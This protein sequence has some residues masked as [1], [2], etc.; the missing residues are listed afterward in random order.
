MSKKSQ[1]LSLSSV[2][3]YATV[4]MAGTMGSTSSSPSDFR[5]VVALLGGYANINASRSQ[6]FVGTD[7]ELFIYRPANNGQ[8]SGFFG[9]FAGVEHRLPWANLSLQGGVEYDYYWPAHVNGTNTVGIQPSTS[10]LYN[11]QYS[12]DTQQLL[13]AFKLFGTVR[14][15]FHPYFSFGLGMAFNNASQFTTFTSQSGS[16]NLTPSFIDQD[17]T[18]FSYNLGVGVDVNMNENVRLGLGYRYS[19][20]GNISFTNGQ[21]VLNSYQFPLPFNLGAANADAHELLAQLTYVF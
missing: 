16:L 9:G 2:L 18:Q 8:N 3:L 10:T 4:S 6:T 19:N 1:A 7:D 14:Q 17:E 21:I 12:V 15:V 20:F 5:P 13:A 11:Y